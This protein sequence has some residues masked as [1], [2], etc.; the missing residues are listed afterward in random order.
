MFS[1]QGKSYND[2]GMT[3][4]CR[5]FDWQFSADSSSR[6]GFLLTGERIKTGLV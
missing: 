4:P 3:G 2:D 5:G 1:P 6:S